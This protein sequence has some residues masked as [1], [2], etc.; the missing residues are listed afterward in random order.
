MTSFVILS[1]NSRK[2]KFNLVNLSK[3]DLI[4]H[5]AFAQK[6]Y[7]SL[8]N[9][10][11]RNRKLLK[12]FS[13]LDMKS[14]NYKFLSSTLKVCNWWYTKCF[15]EMW[16]G[17]ATV[18]LR[19]SWIRWDCTLSFVC[20]SDI[21]WIDLINNIFENFCS[22]I[23]R[24]S[25]G[26]FALAWGTIPG[27]FDPDGSPFKGWI[28]ATGKMALSEKQYGFGDL[29]WP[30]F[31][32]TLLLIHRRLSSS[33]YWQFSDTADESTLGFWTLKTENCPTLHTANDWN[34]YE[35]VSG[36]WFD[37]ENVQIRKVFIL[38][39]STEYDIACPL[40]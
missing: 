6:Y 1:K 10:N 12:S 16:I 17:K 24:M 32:L 35:P 26:K 39:F 29:I 36:K 4:K 38:I 21:S 22:V 14:M 31:D 5:A 15:N 2:K 30:F 28:T 13:R 23:P 27:K 18:L 34:V 37:K 33:L 19:Y 25:N 11:C 20:Q 8:Q 7:F 3:H 9:A 40:K